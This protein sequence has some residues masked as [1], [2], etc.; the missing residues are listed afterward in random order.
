M[1]FRS[2]S[3]DNGQTWHSGAAVNDGRRVNNTEIQSS[4]MNHPS[5]QNTEAT[6]VQLANGQLK[7]FMRGLTRDLQVATSEDGGA[8]SVSYTH[9]NSFFDFIAKYCLGIHG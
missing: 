7:M 6:I 2:Y 9:L 4:T 3:D 5:A 8:T 1:L